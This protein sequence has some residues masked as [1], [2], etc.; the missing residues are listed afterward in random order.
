MF[1]YCQ[2]N[3]LIY[4]DTNGQC[5]EVGALLTWIDCK[6]PYCPTSSRNQPS[7]YKT[8]KKKNALVS[9]NGA[10]ASVN[11]GA[12]VATGSATLAVDTKGNMQ[13]QYSFGFDVSTSGSLSASVGLVNNYCI[14]PDIS[15]MLGD[16]YNIGSGVAVPLPNTPLTVSKSGSIFQSGDGYWGLSHASGIAGCINADMPIGAISGSEIHGGYSFAGALTPAINIF[17]ILGAS[18]S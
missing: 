13:L 14:A 2:N 15:T 18:V 8:G 7:R 6:S 3:P 10:Y 4:T 1:A 16:A 5:R 11:V 17:E 12:F 9:S